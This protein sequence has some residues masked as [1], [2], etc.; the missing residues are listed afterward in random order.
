MEAKPT[1]VRVDWA[2][3]YERPTL[4]RDMWLLLDAG[5]GSE[6]NAGSWGRAGFGRQDA[7]VGKSPRKVVLCYRIVRQETECK[8]TC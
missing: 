5:T 4:P 7:L 6:Q 3:G 1:C 2:G 8:K